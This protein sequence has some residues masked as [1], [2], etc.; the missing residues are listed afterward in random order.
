MLRLCPGDNLSQRFW[1][2][3]VL[4]HADRASDALSFAQIW[5]DPLATER[6]MIPPRGGTAFLPP[7]S[8]VMPD[9]RYQQLQKWC[10]GCLAYTGA[11]ASFKLWG[12]CPLAR[13]YLRIGV[14]INPFILTKILSRAEPPSMPGF[15]QLSALSPFLY[16]NSLRHPEQQRSLLDERRRRRRPGNSRRR[17][18]HVT[19]R[20]IPIRTIS[21]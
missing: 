2:G 19:L 20:L 12:N 1:A 16:L 11:L 7:S 18:S 13:Q 6:G 10:K 9:E 3:S 21:G 5:L 8:E 17:T 14:A 15:S 4:L